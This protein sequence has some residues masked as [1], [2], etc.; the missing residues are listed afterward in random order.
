MTM[1]WRR[2]P[3]RAAALV[4]GAGLLAS[5]CAETARPPETSVVFDEA[6][7][8]ATV[9]SVD[10]DNRQ[11]LLRADDGETISFTAGPEI[12]NLPQLQPGD[13][14]TLDFV[15]AVAARLALPGDPDE[16]VALAAMGRAPE[17]ER[18]GGFVTSSVQ[19]TVEFQA[20]DPVTN[21]VSYVGPDGFADSFALETPEMRAFAAGLRPGDRVLVTVI[22]SV[23]LTVD[24]PE[25]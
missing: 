14:V 22:E 10:L 23:A 6:V 8:R 1:A 18:P 9:Q 24:G 16:P 21:V 25:G 20:F 12:R 4:L 19:M 17:G 15:D 7:L 13:R 11:V 5:A 2:S 3:L